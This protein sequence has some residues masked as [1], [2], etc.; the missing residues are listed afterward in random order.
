MITIVQWHL[1]HKTTCV[2][3]SSI[4]PIKSILIQL[5]LEISPIILEM[6]P[7]VIIRDVIAFLPR[8][9]YDLE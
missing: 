7:E 3:I 4:P 2:W 5:P 9:Q 6:D 8:V 1:L